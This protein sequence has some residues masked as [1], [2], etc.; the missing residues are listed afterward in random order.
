[1]SRFVFDAASGNYVQQDVVSSATPNDVVNHDDCISSALAEIRK[2]IEIMQAILD[3][4]HDEIS[5]IIIYLGEETE[6]EDFENN[7]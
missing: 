3:S 7:N 5:Q 1:M 6:E 2:K 4:H